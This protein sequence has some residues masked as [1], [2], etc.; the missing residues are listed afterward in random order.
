MPASD[1]ADSDRITAAANRLQDNLEDLQIRLVVQCPAGSLRSTADT[2]RDG[3]LRKVR[4]QLTARDC[5]YVERTL[6]SD[7]VA[8]DTREDLRIDSKAEVHLAW[9]PGRRAVGK[10]P[11]AQRIAPWCVRQALFP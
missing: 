3:L 9:L 8:C 4:R 11:H 5:S 6:G 10:A 2:T 7:S 1:Q